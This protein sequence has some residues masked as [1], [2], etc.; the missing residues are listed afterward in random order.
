MRSGDYRTQE[1]LID[2]LYNYNNLKNALTE[3]EPTK[4]YTIY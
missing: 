2:S 4:I 3:P 1:A